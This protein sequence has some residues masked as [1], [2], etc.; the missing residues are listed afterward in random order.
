M[1]DCIFYKIK[2]FQIGI[3]NSTF[4]FAKYKWDF[5]TIAQNEESST[6]CFTSQK[7]LASFHPASKNIRIYVWKK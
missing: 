2:F 3:R 6:L 1:F 7:I 5:K 4:Y